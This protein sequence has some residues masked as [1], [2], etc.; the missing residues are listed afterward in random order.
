MLFLSLASLLSRKFGHTGGRL[1]NGI[2]PMAAAGLHR[3]K[4]PRAAQLAPRGG[5]VVPSPPLLFF[6]QCPLH[7]TP[8][9]NAA[10]KPSAHQVTKALVSGRRT[11][12]VSPGN[13]KLPGIETTEGADLG[14]E[15]PRSCLQTSCLSWPLGC[16]CMDLIQT[17]N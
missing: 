9:V 6:S 15:T 10:P 1:S 11:A 5:A 7:L 12:K 8:G 16:T 4:T 3:H 14:N 2:D 13:W 17:G